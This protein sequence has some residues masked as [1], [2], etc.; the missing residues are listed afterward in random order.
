MVSANASVNPVSIPGLTTIQATE[1]TAPPAWALLERQLI[2]LM[3]E[4]APLMIKKHTEPGGAFLY[5]DDLDDL[6]ERCYNWGLFYA[7][8]ADESLLDMALTA[9][10]AS[11][12]ISDEGIVHRKHPRFTQSAYRE[13]YSLAHPGDAEWHHK[14]EGNMAFYDFGLACPTVSENVRRAKQFAGWYIGEDAHAPNYDKK[15]K[16]LRSPSQTGGGPWHSATLYQTMG[17]LQGGHP[18]LQ[19]PWIPKP[20]GVRASLYPVVKE[21]ED[22]WWENPARADEIIALFDK[23]VLNSDSSNNLAAVGLVTNAFLYTS[24][25]K[26]KKWVLDYTEAWMERTRENNGILPDN[27]GPTG[28]IGENR[29]GQ[30]WGGLY[31]WNHYQGLNIMFHGLITAVEC[32]LLLTGDFGYLDLL[33]SQINLLLENS[34]TRE[35]GQLLTPARYGPDGWDSY[36]PMRILEIAHLYHASMSTEDYELFARIRAGDIERDWNQ[37]EDSAEKNVQLRDGHQNMARFNYYDGRNPD[38]PEQILRSEYRMALSAS[39]HIRRDTRDLATLIAENAYAYNPVFTKGL[40]QV[41]LGAP[42]SVYNGG[43]L[44][45]S[46][47]YFDPDRERPGLPRDVTALVDKLESDATGVQLVNLSTTEA[48]NLIVGAGAFGEHRFTDVRFKE[49]NQQGLEKNPYTWMR[50]KREPID[51]VVPI[52]GKYFAVQLPPATSIRLDIG[53]KRFANQPSYAFPWHGDKIPVPFQ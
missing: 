34:I 32:A 1:I 3:E 45:A 23:I 42:Q 47:R 38:W 52:N 27:V 19:D 40:T 41:M 2:N 8:G 24:D 29:H 49:V 36:Q 51:K 15:Y 46:V 30:W 5:S 16:I 4:A 33:R 18:A 53:M 31:G 12:R 9:W 50:E 43:L 39:E 25:E 13:Y 10:N 35:D 37:V 6:Y 44:R 14:G 28:K 21:L 26:Y 7:M 17:Y 11:T 22:G 20:M 48:R